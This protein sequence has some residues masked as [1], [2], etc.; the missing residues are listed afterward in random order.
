MEDMAELIGHHFISRHHTDTFDAATGG[1][2]TTT[3][4]CDKKHHKVG[5]R[6]PLHEIVGGK[7]G[8]GLQRHDMER[9]I[10]ERIRQ[11]EI[12]RHVKRCR[13]IDDDKRTDGNETTQFAIAPY[14][15]PVTLDEEKVK[16][17][18]INGGQ[19]HEYQL[20]ILNE[21]RTEPSDTIGMSG[22]SAGCHSGHSV[23]DCIEEAHAAK[24]ERSGT[25][26]CQKQ[27]Y[28]PQ[29]TCRRT[30][31]SGYARTI[32]IWEARRHP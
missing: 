14:I 21:R 27:V 32:W 4:G 20:H 2:C 13:H 31:A 24:I 28:S 17:C 29:P 22:K 9:G 7:A 19:K 12:G 11:I 8:G 1:T 15:A 3:H 6:V 23:I 25:S 16:Q 5:G 30:D 26:N 10:A 18:E